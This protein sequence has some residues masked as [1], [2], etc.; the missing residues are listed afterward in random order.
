MPL[1]LNVFLNLQ[2]KRSQKL[3]MIETKTRAV[4]ESALNS[5]QSYEEL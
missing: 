1:V 4:L 5:T 2:K 3:S